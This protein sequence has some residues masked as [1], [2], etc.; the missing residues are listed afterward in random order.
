MKKLTIIYGLAGLL[1]VGCTSKE[2]S[3]E[4]AYQLI[5][6]SQLYPRIL[7]FDIHCSDPQ[8]AQ[9]VLAA[10]LE[11]EGLV[12][13][14]KTQKLGNVGEPLILFTPKA[15][16]YL[17]PTSPE[18]KELDVQKVKLAEEELV[19]VTSVTTEKDGNSAVVEYSTAYKNVNSFAALRQNGLQEK[20]NRKVQVFRQNNE[21]Q[22][23][24][25]K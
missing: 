3:R 21:W 20:V 15:Q 9:S 5:Q 16:P 23:G 17:L 11:K 2:L 19:E 4:E 22:I 18:D 8:Q 7:D 12:T 1:V 14:Q 24:M 25:K 13:V 6:E 10:G